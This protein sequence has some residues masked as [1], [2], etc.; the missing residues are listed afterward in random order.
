[1]SISIKTNIL[2]KITQ[3]NTGSWEHVSHL[4]FSLEIEDL[5]VIVRE[6]ISVDT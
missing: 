4:H 6:L 3:T 2:L 1:M 5:I